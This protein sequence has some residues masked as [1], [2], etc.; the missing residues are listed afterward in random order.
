MLGRCEGLEG[1]VAYSYS[2]LYSHSPLRRTKR[3]LLPLT[4]VLIMKYDG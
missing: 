4:S 3:T 1:K 2:V